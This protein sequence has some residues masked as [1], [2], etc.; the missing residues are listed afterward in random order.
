MQKDSSFEPRCYCGQLCM[1]DNAAAAAAIAG[2][3]LA[4]RAAGHVLHVRGRQYAYVAADDDDSVCTRC[5][6]ARLPWCVS[7]RR[8]VV[9]VQKRGSNEKQRWESFAR[10]GW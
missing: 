6:T 3:V 10:T 5:R 9:L 1:G 8:C 7:C 2:V 4:P